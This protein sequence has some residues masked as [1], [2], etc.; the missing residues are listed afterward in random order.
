MKKKT[1]K[2]VPDHLIQHLWVCEYPECP[3][4]HQPVSVTPNFY[5][6]SGTPICSS[7][8]EDL[9]YQETKVKI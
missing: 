8:D 4:F 7:C 3:E 5:A 6:E 1:W 2:T 9:H